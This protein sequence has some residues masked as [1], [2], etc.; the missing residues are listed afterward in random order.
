MES[1]RVTYKNTELD[2]TGTLYRGGWQGWE[3]E[4]TVSSFEIENIECQGLDLSEL[5]QDDKREI[6]TLILNEIL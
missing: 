6:E 4:P 3:T 5:L 2:V 1:H